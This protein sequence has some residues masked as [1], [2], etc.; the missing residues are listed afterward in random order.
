MKFRSY[1]FIQQKDE[2]IRETLAEELTPIAGLVCVTEG[3][4]IPHVNEG[5]I[6]IPLHIFGDRLHLRMSI[7]H[8]KLFNL[9]FG[10]V[11]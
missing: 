6:E 10:Q 5:I 1:Y 7:N 2:A 8:K 3:Q 9:H 11:V 4:F